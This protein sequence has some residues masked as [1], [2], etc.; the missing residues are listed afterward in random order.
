MPFLLIGPEWLLRFSLMP[1]LFSMRNTE[2]RLLKPLALHTSSMGWPATYRLMT[3]FSLSSFCIFA[4]ET[5]GSDT[6]IFS[7]KLTTCSADLRRARTSSGK[8]PIISNT[9][10]GLVS[11][12]SS[13][14]ESIWSWMLTIRMTLTRQ[15]SRNVANSRMP[16]KALENL[17][18]TSSSPLYRATISCFQSGLL[19][20]F[21]SLSLTIRMQP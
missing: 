8:A 14:L 10:D 2:L 13:F 16:R 12:N 1:C 9:S 21:S 11:G 20:S 17:D 5:G 7:C 3:V 6:I 18:M 15:N 19:R 4:D